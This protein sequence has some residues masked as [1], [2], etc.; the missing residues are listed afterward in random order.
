MAAKNK[1]S[2]TFI[3]RIAPDQQCV[4]VFVTALLTSAVPN[5]YSHILLINEASANVELATLAPAAE[6]PVKHDFRESHPSILVDREIP[7]VSSPVRA[8]T[9]TPLPVVQ[10]PVSTQAK[11]EAASVENREATKPKKA[12]NF[13]KAQPQ[14]TA[15]RMNVIGAQNGAA[16]IVDGNGDVQKVEVGDDIPGIGKLGVIRDDRTIITADGRQVITESN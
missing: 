11:P 3:G 7:V 9:P 12:S 16:W 15:L 1:R 4:T 10:K 5:L 6:S 8:I 13:R 14:T 2:L